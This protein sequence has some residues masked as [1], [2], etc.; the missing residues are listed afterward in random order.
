MEWSLLHEGAGRLAAALSEG[1]NPGLALELDVGGGGLVEDLLGRVV[2]CVAQRLDHHHHGE[3]GPQ[4]GP[5]PNQTRAAQ[6]Q[7]GESDQGQRQPAPLYH[8]ACGLG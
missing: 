5:Q 2:E 8:Q 4:V 6:Q 3:H 7:R 1:V